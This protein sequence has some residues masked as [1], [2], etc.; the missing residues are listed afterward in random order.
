MGEAA[1]SPLY[2]HVDMYTYMIN[3]Y[4]L[5]F[6]CNRK[7]YIILSISV[8]GPYTIQLSFVF[9]LLLAALN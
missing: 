2:N 1:P 3:I 6:P 7:A 5:L 4:Q 9:H 8:S